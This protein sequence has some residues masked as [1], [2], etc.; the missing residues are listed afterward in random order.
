[1]SNLSPTRSVTV[2][3]SVAS[4]RAVASP[5]SASSMRSTYPA[6]INLRPVSPEVEVV[7]GTREGT[8]MRTSPVRSSLRGSR[9]VRSSASPTPRNV[10]I[11]GVTTVDREPSSIRSS[12]SRSNSV[13]PS[14]KP[15]TPILVEVDDPL[16][17]EDNRYEANLVPESDYEPAVVTPVAQTRRSSPIRSSVSGSRTG[18]RT[19]SR[20]VPPSS[21]ISPPQVV[22]STRVSPVRSVSSVSSRTPPVMSRLP[23]SSVRAVSKVGSD[24]L[25][26][27]DEA[28]V[29]YDVFIEELLAEHGFIVTDRIMVDVKGRSEPRYMVVDVDGGRAIVEIDEDGKVL[30]SSSRGTMIAERTAT[31]VPE[32][33]IISLEQCT[34]GTGCGVAFMCEGEVCVRSRSA[35]SSDVPTTVVLREMSAPSN[36]VM[37]VSGVPTPYP[38]VRLS[39]V[40]ADP[41]NAKQ[42]I[43]DSTRIIRRNSYE[44][45]TQNW[46]SMS[47]SLA[48]LNKMAVLYSQ[49][50]KDYFF[51]LGADNDVLTD[52]RRQYRASPPTNP[53]DARRYDLVIE[54]LSIRTDMINRLFALCNEIPLITEAIDSET[55]RIEEGIENIDENTKHL[56]EAIG[57]NK[58]EE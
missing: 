37:S 45:C 17:S 54:N 57:M 21:S 47:E 46:K 50:T 40:L 3:R 36:D 23:M 27:E 51:R 8:P 35:D 2:P 52:L 49:K 31:V 38:V 48:A 15:A 13:Q 34:R 16:S 32:S 5:L 12:V 6:L 10:S 56:G 33:R 42:A 53:E 18:S 30:Y 43:E 11:G 1:M 41:A 19:A 29:V 14:V 58:S 55:H 4:S 9:S 28:G 25:R 24:T 26:V 44:E 39:E 20:L 7:S 22:T